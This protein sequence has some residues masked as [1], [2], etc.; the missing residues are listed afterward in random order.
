MRLHLGVI[1][2]PHKSVMNHSFD[3]G[4][5]NWTL[6]KN[7]SIWNSTSPNT[8]STQN[9][10]HLEARDM[11]KTIDADMTSLEDILRIPSMYDKIK[12]MNMKTP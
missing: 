9:G 7:L 10:D 1:I 6:E 4:P 8:M 12:R 5:A 3:Y 11:L 2:Q